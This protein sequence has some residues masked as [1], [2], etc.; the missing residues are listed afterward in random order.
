M[1]GW[2]GGD[3]ASAP[4]RVVGGEWVREAEEGEFAA[5]FEVGASSR[6]RLLD[7]E[8]TDD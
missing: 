8:D 7:S 4:L 2:L 1:S 3:I 5:P 6:G